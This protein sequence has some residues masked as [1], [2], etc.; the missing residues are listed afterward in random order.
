M[1]AQPAAAARKAVLSS[2]AAPHSY[3]WRE[4]YLP[5]LTSGP[6]GA[7]FSSDG[8]EVIYSQGG[9]L[10]RQALGGDE[11]VELT[12][13]PGYDY[14]PDWSRDGRAVVFVRHHRDALE[15]WYLDLATGRLRASPSRR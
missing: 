2:V 5:Q 3:Y 11:A 8:T 4:L 12:R 6:S 14:Q 1:T 13:G 15:R 7:T 10:W 9:S